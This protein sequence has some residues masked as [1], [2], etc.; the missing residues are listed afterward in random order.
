[1]AW[2]RALHYPRAQDMFDEALAIRRRTP[3]EIVRGD[4]SRTLEQGLSLIPMNQVPLVFS[5][6]VA[7]QMPAPSESDWPHSWPRVR[8]TGGCST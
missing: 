7:Y 2:M 4:A 3:I 5:T 8:G 6:G 1:V